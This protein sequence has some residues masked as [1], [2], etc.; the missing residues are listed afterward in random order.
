MARTDRTK[1]KVAQL[2]EVL[3]D[4]QTLAI[5]MQNYPDPDAIASAAAL[6]AIAHQVGGVRTTLASGGVA[7]R[8]ENRALLQYLRIPCHRTMEVE[9]ER[10][11]RVALVDTQPCTGNNALPSEVQPHIV[12]DHHPIQKA[13]RQAAFTDVRSGYGATSTIL[14]EY[15]RAMG[16]EIDKQLAT[17]LLYGI[18]SDTQDLG[19]EAAQADIRAIQR[20]TPLANL[21]MLSA[22][23]YSCTP[24]SYF[25][26]LQSAL[27]HA[28]V[29]G[30]AIVS[31]LGQIDIPDI[32]G[33]IADLFLRDEDATWALCYGFYK[34]QLLLSLRTS[35]ADGDAGAVM[36]RLVLGRGTGGGHHTMAGGQI[37][38]REDDKAPTCDESAAWITIRFLRTIGINEDNG[39]PLVD[40]KGSA[41]C[42][43]K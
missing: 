31:C 6:R 4:T 19:R 1:Q 9:F 18:R 29:H 40:C 13:T 32:T 37:V 23:Q 5:V 25:R 10:F 11:D 20:L 38:L 3:K 34:Q 2:G 43:M 27:E 30:P 39:T 12:I 36:R 35:D 24:R 26:M 33:E 8:A 42:R 7:G 16:T 17:A 22:I 15:L 21:R 14:H 28:Q 41:I